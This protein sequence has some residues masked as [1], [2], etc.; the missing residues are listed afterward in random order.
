VGDLDETGRSD[1]VAATTD[2]LVVLIN[3]GAE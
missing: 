1:I 3:T 2:N